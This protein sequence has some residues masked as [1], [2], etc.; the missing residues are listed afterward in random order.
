MLGLPD[1]PCMPGS[2]A[3][4]LLRVLQKALANAVKHAQAQTIHVRLALL[5]PLLLLEIVD[6]G[7]GFTAPGPGLGKG[8]PGMHKRAWG[9]G[10]QLLVT[11]STQGSYC[12]FQRSWTPVSV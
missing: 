2:T 9:L 6:D 5:P 11:S 7:C 3:L 1:A 12:V 8:L 4:P 10:V